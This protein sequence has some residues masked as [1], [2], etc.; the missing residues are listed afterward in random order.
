MSDQLKELALA[1][2]ASMFGD[3]AAELLATGGLI[4]RVQRY[5]NP[6]IRYGYHLCRADAAHLRSYGTVDANA[7]LVIQATL[8]PL[9]DDDFREVRAFDGEINPARLGRCAPIEWKRG[10]EV[11][12]EMLNNMSVARYLAQE[13]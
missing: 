2:L 8:A 6:E 10:Q 1:R 13:A 12:P 5:N 7:D 11:A 3:D 4:V 9:L